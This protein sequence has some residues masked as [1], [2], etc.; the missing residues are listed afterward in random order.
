MAHST[1][2]NR[3]KLPRPSNLNSQELL[4]VIQPPEP[5]FETQGPLIDGLVL[6]N[7]YDRLLELLQSLPPSP[8]KDDLYLLIDGFLGDW[9]AFASFGLQ[10]LRDRGYISLAGWNA[11]QSTRVQSNINAIENGVNAISTAEAAVMKRRRAFL[12]TLSDDSQPLQDNLPQQKSHKSLSTPHCQAKSARA[13]QAPKSLPSG[14]SYSSRDQIFSRSFN[15]P[16]SANTPS[17]AVAI[18]RQTYSFL[19]G[20]QQ[21]LVLP[22]LR[23][24]SFSNNNLGG[25]NSHLKSC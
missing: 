4:R 10:N 6:L 17:E 14:D 7:Q 3:L 25:F 8:T 24:R 19:G 2:S 13:E 15:A 22:D 5:V 1:M 12:Q 11:I 20:L 16:P 23:Q 9:E 18:L 21:R